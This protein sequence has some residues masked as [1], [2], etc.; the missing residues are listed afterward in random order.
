MVNESCLEKDEAVGQCC[1][2]KYT[3]VSNIILMELDI[4]WLLALKIVVFRRMEGNM[5]I[6]ILTLFHNNYNWGGVL[7]GYALKQLLEREIPA[8]QVDI[9]I[10]E[11]GKNVIYTNKIRQAMQY[12]PREII[13][14]A[15]SA[16]VMVEK[17]TTDQ[18]LKQRYYLFKNFME[19]NTTNK[20][21]Y[22]DENLKSAA[23]EYDYLI[24]GSD[25]VWNP[26]V[27]KAGYFQEMVSN[28]CGKIS[29][30][31]SIARDDLSCHERKIMIPLIERFDAISVREKTA[32]NIL[33]KYMTSKK[34][35]TEV[36]D[37][38]LML[39]REEWEIFAEQNEGSQEK[40]ALAFFFSKS[41]KYRKYVTNY[42]KEQGLILKFIP[43]ARNKYIASDDKGSCE[44]LYDVGPK[45]FV[46]LFRDAEYIF[47]DSFH[48]A[49]FSINFEKQFVVFE[50]DKNTKVS[51]NSRLYDLLE[52]F[53][54]SERLV[55]G[56]IDFERIVN[57]K[58]DFGEIEKFLNK[59][60]KDSL[61]FLLNALQV[62]DE[63]VNKEKVA[64]VI[65][66]PGNECCGCSLCLSSCPKNCI[67]MGEDEEGFLYPHIDENSCVSCGKC[68]KTCKN[69]VYVQEKNVKGYVGYHADEDVRVRSSSGGLFYALAVSVLNQGGCV[70]GAAF[71]E[72]FEV[73]HR[74]ITRKDELPFL[75][76]SKYVQSMTNLVFQQIYDDLQNDK[77]VL[78]SGTPCQVAAVYRYASDKE[79]ANRLLL[80][81]FI[82]HGVPSPGVW[83]S[84]LRYLE[85]KQGSNLCQVNFRDKS[86]GWHDYH[87]FAK[88]IKGHIKE[89]HELN[90]YMRTFLSD[91]NIRPSCYDCSFKGQNYYS[92]ITLGDAWKIEKD[93][94]AWAD[95][96]GTSFFVVRTYKGEKL[97]NQVSDVFNYKEIDYEQ[98]KKFNPSLV[99][100]TEQPNSRKNFFDGYI[101]QD[102]KDFWDHYS[103]IEIKQYVRYYA[104]RLLKILRLEKL[105]RK[106]I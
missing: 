87:F 106:I 71:N 45:E 102:A 30:A 96:K 40:Y 9:L 90:P 38:A 64:N 33:E 2:D 77:V 26:N 105:I 60:R 82:C 65:Q 68:V 57:K 99:K 31:A 44:R 75:M 74:R 42:C 5:K 21:I 23:E 41:Y 73:E 92:D 37:P 85:Q 43:Y 78:F 79:V 62:S 16:I 18:K 86:F 67:E 4:S 56:R 49:A 72:N 1:S 84:Y 29:Y 70:Y 89:S 95:N 12:T 69:R 13:C 36:L 35:V 50:R 8:V 104:K 66:L 27:G 20:K 76:T 83:R 7:Q 98:W 32:K 46:R 52:K 88:F 94:P 61:N 22:C 48:G 6:G 51:K 101:K 103:K 10:Y 53:S 91:K 34:M 14:K 80:I 19:E 97:L 81:D 24:S 54:L 15:L 28:Q 93:F 100:A 63:N 3:T 55:K 17:R 11:N 58:I 59:Y 39:S 25:Q 47:T